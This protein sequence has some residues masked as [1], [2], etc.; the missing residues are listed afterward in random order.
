MDDRQT[1]GRRTNIKNEDPYQKS[2][3]QVMEKA[4]CARI[5]Q[6]LLKKTLLHQVDHR[7]QKGQE[8]TKGLSK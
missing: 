2:G 7:T 4:H 5:H 8:P 1:K 3:N 6:L